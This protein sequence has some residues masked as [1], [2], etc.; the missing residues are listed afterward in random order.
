MRRSARARS[1][2]WSLGPI[3]ATA[4][5]A[6]IT[7][8]LPARTT[9]AQTASVGATQLSER[10][11]FR[12]STVATGLEHP[13]GGTFLPDGR[14]LLTER[15]GRV[16][17]LIREGELSPPLAGVPAVE[18]RGQG[19]LLDIALAP[20][21]ATTR[22][23]YLCQA[24]LVQ[25]GA[26]TRLVRARLAADGSALEGARP[27]LDATPAQ[28]SSRNHYGCRIAFDPRDG[29]LFLSTG[30]RFDD[31]RRAQRPG[32]LA[33]KVLRLDREGRPLA[34]NPF[35]GREGARAEIWTL[36][37]RNPQG[38]AF[39]PWTGSLWSAEFGP[40]GGDEVNVLRRGAN[41]GWPVV[42]HG[43]MYMGGL[44][45]GEGTSKPGLEDP[46][47]VWVP[48]VSPSGMAFYTGDAFPGWRG[49]LFLA[50]LNPPALVRLSTEGDRV[51][52]EER[53]LR[54]VARFR[55]VVQGPDG[56]LY[57]LTDEPRGRVLR[58]EPS[59]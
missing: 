2:A 26:L 11:Q 14:L 34:D 22:E 20:D 36:G 35:V 32:D 4:A 54:G 55:H 41:Y 21:F 56:L 58:L 18:A 9:V 57:I 17:L 45:I 1:G 29:Q 39:N 37:H 27:V 12:V 10:A 38:L 59:G 49:S 51:A 7:A 25:G 46:I 6:L 5:V 53:L 23:V 16:R 44:P 15:P 8:G 19:G 31:E 3:L 43:R 24:A 30:E 28:E 50:G 47:H 33:G 40:R 42:S 48:S 13:W 52:G